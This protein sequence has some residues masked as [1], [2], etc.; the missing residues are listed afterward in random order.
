MT[1]VV[2]LQIFS[3]VLLVV[4]SA[5]FSSAETAYFSLGPLSLNRLK[6]ERPA[7]AQ[8][9]HDLLR[10]PDRLLST[11]LIGNT[12]VNISLSV[13]GYAAFERLWP[14]RGELLA[15]PSLTLLLLVCGEIV[16]KR[17]ALAYAGRMA[18]AYALPLLVLRRL[19]LPLRK[20]LE[21]V[22]KVLVPAGAGATHALT[23][24]EFK[25]ALEEGRHSGVVD[26][27]ERT[28]VR[29]IIRL[30]DLHANDVMTPRVDLAGIDLHDPPPDMVLR[31]REARVRQWLVYRDNLDQV[32]GLLDVK[33]FLLD[34]ERD[35]QKALRPAVFVPES[36]PL[37]A[38]LARFQKER[39]HAVVVVDEYGGT[40][41]LVTHGDILEEIAGEIGEDEDPRRPLLHAL[42]AGRWVADGYLPL[43]ELNE[44]LGLALHSEDSDR[45]AGW[46]MDHVGR[47]P[48][49]GD[50]VTAQGIH[51][52][53]RRMRRH[54]VERVALTRMPPPGVEEAGA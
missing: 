11:I 23:E 17:L 15:I 4:C 26:D 25:T 16:P 7:T 2:L 24:D 36:A 34:P 45:L 10:T 40:A 41:G 44:M 35:L 48:R 47:I 20:G 50:E 19:S 5:F 52:E 49:P 53:V 29:G 43:E 21:R 3:L 51:A 38:L 39:L 32:E 37:D 12:L 6:Q 28:M 22:N 27:E 8:R 1:S 9:V 30:G 42:G 13:L 33:T 14:G 46:I 18:G 31:L 54:R